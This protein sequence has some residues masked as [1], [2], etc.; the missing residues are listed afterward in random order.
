MEPVRQ[1]PV[2]GWMSD[3]NVRALF[4]VLALPGDPDPALLFVGGCVRN[5]LLD[6]PVSDVD[7][8]T[9]HTP[10]A[11]V[12]R[13]EAADI[14]FLTVGIDHGTVTARFGSRSFEITTLRVDMETDGRRARVAY[15]DDW[16][17]D[18]ARRD[19]T[20]NALYADPA[21]NLYDPL[22]G[23]DDV[24]TGRVRFI[25]DPHE[26]IAE[27]ALRI[28]RFFRF[29]AQLA[30]GGIDPDGLAACRAHAE[31]LD[32]LSGERIRDELLKLLAAP[33]PASTF[34][35]ME[36]AGIAAHITPGATG[37]ER[38]AALVTIEGVANGGDPLRRFAAVLQRFEDAA[39][40][41]ERLR[42][43][44][45]ETARLSAMVGRDVEIVPELPAAARRV[46]LY[47]TGDDLWRDTVL[48]NWADDIVAG[49]AI[50]RRRTDEW[51]V[52]LDLPRT[53]AI[54]AFPL[55]GA[56]VLDAG[57]PEGPDVGRLLS[58]IEEWW[59][60]GGFAA[61]RAACLAEL[62][63]RKDAI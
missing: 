55:R 20:V 5:H 1:I 33:Q 11:I 40:A 45:A 53:D 32:G 10:E 9:V 31:M 24:A 59:I 47:R 28:L 56:D 61:D 27:D 62:A 41:G 7:L 35:Q 30:A 21:G 8:A 54:P 42:L 17:A 52:L 13:L 36:G 6:R 37:S 43:S 44:R 22:G 3:A 39:A 15:T 19:F 58:E 38:L 16:A 23:I 34:A 46:R 60:A 2:A 26:R 63:R 48:L 12:T 57:L 49:G 14:S 25:G 18:A 50:E 51:R 29:H 4:E